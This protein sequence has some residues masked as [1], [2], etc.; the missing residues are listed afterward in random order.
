MNER[1][2]LVNPFS[3]TEEPEV[4]PFRCR[5]TEADAWAYASR[6]YRADATVVILTLDEWFERGA[7]WAENE[8][9]GVARAEIWA[10]NRLEPDPAA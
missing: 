5:G 9:A 8:W 3:E 2:V 6:M 4:R 1:W 7:A 10:N